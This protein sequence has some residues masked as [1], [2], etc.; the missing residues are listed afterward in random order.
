MVIQNTK[1]FSLLPNLR[2]NKSWI[3]SAS[4]FLCAFLVFASQAQAAN[5]PAPTL[6]VPEPGVRLGQD[7]VWVGGVSFNDTEITI[8]VDDEEKTSVKTRN[9]QSGVGNFGVELVNL[10]LGSHKITSISRDSKGRTSIISNVL[11]IKVEPKTPAPTKGM[12]ASL[13]NP[14]TVPSSP[15]TPCSALNTTSA[16]VSAN[17]A[18]TSRSISIRVTRCPR[19]SS[20][21]A[22]PS[23]LMSETGRSADQPPIRTA[24]CHGPRL[25]S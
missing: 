20:A 1:K 18:A 24:T 10:S 19:D 15:G 9:H 3:F 11:T 22:T 23:P 5:L 25:T 17:R 16:F 7:R 13:S 21:L 6:L 14:C 4:L 8:L 2:Q 12:P